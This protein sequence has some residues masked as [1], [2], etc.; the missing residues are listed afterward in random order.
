MQFFYWF[1]LFK[2]LLFLLIIYLNLRLCEVISVSRAGSTVILFGQ[3]GIVPGC[4]FQVSGYS[5]A[6][7]LL[8]EEIG[9]AHHAVEEIHSRRNLLRWF[10]SQ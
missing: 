9:F 1:F 4:I 6:T 10:V 3:F 8:V 7:E 5:G 2:E